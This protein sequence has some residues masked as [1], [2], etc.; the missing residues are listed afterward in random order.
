[1][2]LTKGVVSRAEAVK[3]ASDYVDFV[4]GKGGSLLLFGS[5]IPKFEKLRVG[6][7]VLTHSDDV[8]VIAKVSSIQEGHPDADGP[9]VRVT[10]GEYSWRV[11]GDRY[12]YP[13]STPASTRWKD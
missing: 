11:D 13:L 8:N 5:V 2:K 9:V 12:A 1:M 6:K 3:L 10:N 7:K 4:E